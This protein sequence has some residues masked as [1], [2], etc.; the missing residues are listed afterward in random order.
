MVGFL[1]WLW[2]L[3]SF[4][5][6]IPQ[7]ELRMKL[8]FFRFA[9]IYPPLYSVVCIFIA[10]FQNALT[11]SLSFIVP[12]NLLA[13]ACLLYLTHFVSKGLVRAETNDPMLKRYR[14]NFLLL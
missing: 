8:G 9:L 12:L 5:N 14:I 13:M 4:L 3:G 11:T 2:S 6:S 10:T 7:P 1:A